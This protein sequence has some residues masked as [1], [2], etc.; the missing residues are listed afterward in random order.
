MAN[1]ER[2]RCEIDGMAKSAET[3]WLHLTPISRLEHEELLNMRASIPE[4][5]ATKAAIDLTTTIVRPT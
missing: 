5:A 4:M 3:W 1:D 2:F